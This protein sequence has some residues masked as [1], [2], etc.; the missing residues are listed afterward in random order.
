MELWFHWTFHK[1]GCVIYLMKILIT[2]AFGNVGQNVVEILLE[3]GYSVRCFDLKNSKNVRIKNKLLRKG[4]F[5]IVWGDIRDSG[6]IRQIIQDVEFVI[7][8]AAIIPPLAYEIPKLA[9][10]VNVKGSI[11]LIKASA[12]MK[13]PPKFVYASSIAVHGNRMKNEP[14]THVNDPLQ[15][16]EYDNYAFH[17]IEVEKF[18]RKSRVPW[19]ILRFAAITPYELGWEIPDLMWDIPLDQRIEVADSRDVALA[20]VNALAAETVGKTLFIGGGEGNQL[21]QR[22]YVSM[23]LE[24]IGIGMLPEEAFKKAKTMDD[25]YHCDWMDTEEAQTLLQFQRFTFKDFLRK[26]RKKV[27][28]RRFIITLFRPI[29][30]AVL[31]SKSPYYEKPKT[32][33]IKNRDNRS[34]SNI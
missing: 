9:Y 20:C 33:K 2:G 32:S 27:S 29:A 28:F 24:A 23:I 26:F 21:Y 19:A 30:R 7:H 22:D 31:L 10:D 3:R 16:L 5:E 18:L 1:S 8:L 13:K 4:K 11:S 14:P 15:P 17:K 6:L 25:F 12:L 34:A